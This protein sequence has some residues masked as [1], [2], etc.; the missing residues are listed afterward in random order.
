MKPVNGEIEFQGQKIGVHVTY[1]VRYLDGAYL[2][3]KNQ[4][5]RKTIDFVYLVLLYGDCLLH[6]N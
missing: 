6:M 3:H 1:V 2:V 4:L 5:L